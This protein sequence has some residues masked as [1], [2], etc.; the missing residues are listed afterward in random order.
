[1]K[2]VVCIKQVPNTS[3]VRWTENNTMIREGV[4]SILN[5]F[6]EYAVE[7]ALRIKEQIP[8]TLITV[9]TMGPF[10]AK[11]ALKRAIAMG[12]DQAILL[13]DNKLKGADTLA[14]S[15]TLAKAI[16]EKVGNFD[17]TAL[18]TCIE[19]GGDE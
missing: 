15:R 1:M 11:D 18:F 17:L 10:Q 6:D 2:I 19:Q 9:L 14:T 5:P 4:E 12:S 13:T 7:T 3:E 8:D 16:R